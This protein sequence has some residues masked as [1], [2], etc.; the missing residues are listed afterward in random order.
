MQVTLKQARLLREK[1]QQDMADFLNIHVSTYQKLEQNQEL[2][3]IKQA[4]LIS[5]FLDFD[6]NDIFFSNNSIKRIS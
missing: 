6:V 2:I 1:T 3:T 5:F 4:K